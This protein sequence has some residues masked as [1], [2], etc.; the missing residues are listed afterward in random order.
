MTTTPR[1]GGRPRKEPHEARSEWLPAMRV[2]PAERH[3]IEQMAAR[4]GLP[5]MEYRR[6]AAMGQRI[7]A[8]RSTADDK[9]LVALA[10]VG[11]NLAQIVRALNYRQGIPSDLAETL[12]EVKAAANRIAGQDGK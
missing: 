11:A 8:R 6:R 2:T 9:A 3:H 10:R 5:V 7:V 1:K 4:A 12:A